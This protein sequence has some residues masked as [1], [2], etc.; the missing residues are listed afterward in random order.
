MAIPASSE[1]GELILTSTHARLDDAIAGLLN[2]IIAESLLGNASP[3]D[4][5]CDRS[6]SITAQA[7][8]TQSALTDLV[9]ALLEAIEVHEGGLRRFEL[10]GVMTGPDRCTIWGQA[11]VEDPAPF[12]SLLL[13]SVTLDNARGTF[14]IATRLR[15]ADRAR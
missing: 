14:E 12:C 2:A 9:N 1:Q 3:G 7:R 8:T 13:N 6:A 15:L 5:A 11:C 10:H 4:A